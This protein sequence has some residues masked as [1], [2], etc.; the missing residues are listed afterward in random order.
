M[1]PPAPS[2]S[3]RPRQPN[4]DPVRRRY[5]PRPAAV[6]VHGDGSAPRRA[7]DHSRL[8]LVELGLGDPDRLG[9]V[10]V[11]RPRVDDLVA[12]PGQEGRLDAAWDRLPAVSTQAA[13]DLASP[14]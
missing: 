13:T 4:L 3:S 6:D 2:G 9:E 10:V 8:V 14:G 1:R 11:R 7:D 5:R 12:V